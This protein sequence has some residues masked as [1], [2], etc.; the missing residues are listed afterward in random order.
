MANENSLGGI[1]SVDDAA[2]ALMAR[3]AGSYEDQPDEIEQDEIETGEDDI[4]EAEEVE[5]SEADDDEE[6]DEAEDEDATVDE[7]DDTADEPD[8]DELKK[9]Y[10]RQADYTRK[11][12]EIAEQRKQIEAAQQ[13]FQAQA[14]QQLDALRKA[15]ETYSVPTDEEP[16]WADLARKLDAKEYNSKRAE[17]DDKQAKRREAV[18]LHEQMQQVQNRHI[19]TQETQALLDKMPEWRDETVASSEKQGVVEVGR[20]YGFT[21]DEMAGITD[22][23]MIVALRDLHLA[24]RTEKAATQKKAKPARKVKAAAAP[25][26]VNPVEKSERDFTAR[27]KKSGSPDDAARLLLARGRAK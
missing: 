3:A 26:K 21:E 9:G 2:A 4:E 16:N 19:I 8:A 5:T 23:R 18:Q 6:G 15:V 20:E 12:Q 17:W 1:L 22:H 25:S 10:M 13:D 11:T 27:L 24:K 7:G 14:Q